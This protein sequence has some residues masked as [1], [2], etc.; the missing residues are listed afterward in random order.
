M[1]AGIPSSHGSAARGVLKGTAK[2]V[3]PYAKVKY[4]LLGLGKA[5]MLGPPVV[6]AGIAGFLG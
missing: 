4:V 2:V 6:A 1:V 5:K 3:G